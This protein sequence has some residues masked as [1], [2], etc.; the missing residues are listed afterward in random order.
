MKRDPEFDAWCEQAIAL[1]REPE[2]FVLW[3]RE[4]ADGAR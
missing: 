3:E 4:L 2:D 1:T